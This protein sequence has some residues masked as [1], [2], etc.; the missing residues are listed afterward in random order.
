MIGAKRCW[1]IHVSFSGSGESAHATVPFS[2]STAVRYRFG[3]RV[4][5]RRPWIDGE[6]RWQSTTAAGS[7]SAS[8][9]VANLLLPESSVLDPDPGH[10]NQL[11]EWFRSCIS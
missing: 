2:R 9:T 8:T 1:L 11:W 10:C 7:F 4:I 5:Y 6:D 3:V